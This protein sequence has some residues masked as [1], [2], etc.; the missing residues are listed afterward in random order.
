MMPKNRARQ[1]VVIFLGSSVTFWGW[2]IEKCF[3]N[4][5]WAVLLLLK[6]IKISETPEPP[7]RRWGAVF[8]RKSPQNVVFL[9][10]VLFGAMRGSPATP[11]K[12]ATLWGSCC[13]KT[14]LVGFVANNCWF[15]QNLKK[16]GTT[17]EN[18]LMRRWG[19]RNF[20]RHFWQRAPHQNVANL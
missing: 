14:T 10:W 6:K 8:S 4:K 16:I 2:E 20:D 15:Y 12:S 3:F 1:N 19:G 13:L 5:K 18:W 11:L 17:N 9:V 7:N